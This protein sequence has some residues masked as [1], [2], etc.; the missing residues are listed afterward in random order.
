MTVFVRH[1]LM[2]IMTVDAVDKRTYVIDRAGFFLQG[3]LH[4]IKQNRKNHIQL[5]GKLVKPILLP[6]RLLT[7][8]QKKKCVQSHILHPFWKCLQEFVLHGTPR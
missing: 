1:R 5:I 8:V 2:K 6:N 7:A 3:L 4:H